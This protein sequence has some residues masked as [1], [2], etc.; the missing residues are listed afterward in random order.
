MSLT[1]RA[2]EA[3]EHADACADPGCHAL[4]AALAAALD[5][6]ARDQ[7]TDLREEPD[8]TGIPAPVEAGFVAEIRVPPGVAGN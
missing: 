3:R 2:R 5:A 8:T 6:A 7:L 4:S 1:D